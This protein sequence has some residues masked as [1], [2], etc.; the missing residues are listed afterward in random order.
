[1]QDNDLISREAAMDVIK[2]WVLQINPT[3]RKMLMLRDMQAIEPVDA[4]PARHGRWAHHN[5]GYSD[6]YEC[7]V[8]GEGIVLTARFRYCPNCGAKMD[9][10]TCGPDYCEIG[11]ETDG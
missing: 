10:P 4:A 1:M 11:G 3:A 2:T 6:H 9:A 8:C 5:G 7:T